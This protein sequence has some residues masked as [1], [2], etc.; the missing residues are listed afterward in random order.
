MKS[1]LLLAIILLF[2]PF[3]SIASSLACWNK[4]TLT[5]D[6]GLVKRIIN[7]PA[8]DKPSMETVIL[9]IAGNPKG[10]VLP[11][12]EEFFLKRMVRQSMAN[13]VGIWVNISRSI[14]GGGW[15]GNN[16]II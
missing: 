15:K 12:N 4:Q 5:L 9:E 1:I 10:Y 14:P 11:V 7:L 2:Q 3:N 13:R 16:A 6:N 8:C